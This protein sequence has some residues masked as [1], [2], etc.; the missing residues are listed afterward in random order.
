MFSLE[1]LL[2]TFAGYEDDFCG[3]FCW[4]F[5]W[6]FCWSWVWV[7]INQSISINPKNHQTPK[8]NG[9]KPLTHRHPHNYCIFQSQRSAPYRFCSIAVIHHQQTFRNA[10]KWLSKGR[11]ATT[12]MLLSRKEDP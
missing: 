11:Q 9:K 10:T 1:D 6:R 8:Q 12:R 7:Q 4:T 5:C 3:S 2:M